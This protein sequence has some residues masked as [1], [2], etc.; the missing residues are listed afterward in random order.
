MKYLILLAAAAIAMPALAQ[1]PPPA[2]VPSSAPPSASEPVDPARLAAARQTVDFVWPLGTYARMM[3]GPMMDQ[4]MQSMF[5]VK[6]S[7]FAPPAAGNRKGVDT[8]AANA[9]LRE[10]L[11]SAD[12]RLQ[13]GMRV[14]MHAMTSE[15]APIMTKIEPDLR[16]GL[17]RAFARK[18]T[19]EQLNDLNRFFATPAGRAYAPDSMLMMT[20]PDVI[21]TLAKATPMMMQA[22]PRIMAKVQDTMKQFPPPPSKP[23][24]AAP[25]AHPD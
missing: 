13:D 6:L 18:F 4:I 1:P 14:M 7:D 17:S 3:M 21:R 5:D 12:P 15:M 11:G 10:T 24:A 2:A 22:M 19:V 16:E 9:T 8:K 20:D 23:R 25:P